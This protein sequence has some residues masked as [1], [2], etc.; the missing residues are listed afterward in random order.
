MVRGVIRECCL[1]MKGSK[2][3]LQ[4]SDYDVVTL[5]VMTPGAATADWL[6]VMLWCVVQRG[7]V[8]IWETGPWRFGRMEKRRECVLIRCTARTVVLLQGQVRHVCKYTHPFYNHTEQI[9]QDKKSYDHLNK[10][11]LPDK[12]PKT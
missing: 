6:G 3:T 1:K 2:R 9:S 7:R 8:L 10:D 11:S 12:S 5:A 4:M